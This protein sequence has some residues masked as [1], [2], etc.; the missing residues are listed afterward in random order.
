MS[1]T[2]INNFTGALNLYLIL[3]YLVNTLLLY[4]IIKIIEYIVNFV[5]KIN[6][7]NNAM[8]KLLNLVKNNEI[9]ID[10][11]KDNQLLL[12]NIFSNNEELYKKL[13]LQFN[14]TQDTLNKIIYEAV[15]KIDNMNE[16]TSFILLGF[17]DYYDPN[18]FYRKRY[19]FNHI[20][21]TSNELFNNI[22]G[23]YRKNHFYYIILSQ[24]KFMPNIMKNG[25]Y[26]KQIVNPSITI[27]TNNNINLKEHDVNNVNWLHDKNNTINF[28]PDS[29]D[30]IY[31][32]NS[33]QIEKLNLL[34]EKYGINLLKDDN[35]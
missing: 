1:Q 13:Q 19:F 28:L 32:T 24:L 17:E 7:V 12:K 4:V 21:S 22:N 33:K 2:L 6:V 27:I 11:Y 15:E 30:K 14:E 3:S 34:C 16:R 10:T 29:D 35:K 20:N 18:N 26:L 23:N 9:I 8:P 31:I 5:D 25:I